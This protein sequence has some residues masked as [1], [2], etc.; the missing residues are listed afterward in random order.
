MAFLD[1]LIYGVRD[2][3][4]AGVAVTRR[5]QI[6]FVSGATVV[7][8]PATGRTDV[9]IATSGGAPP[10][11]T[12]IPYDNAGAWGTTIANGTSGQVLS[13]V[14]S[15]PAWAA[16][17]GGAPSG[18]AGGDLSSTYPNP[19]VAK[20]NGVVFPSGGATVG[21]SPH[22]SVAGTVAYN[23]LNLAGGAGWVSGLL[24]IANGG[25]GNAGGV[26]AMAA[27][28]IDWSLTP[29]Y[30]KTLTS[31]ANAITFSNQTAG[32][33]VVVRLTGAASTVTW[34]AGTKWAAG[35]APTQTASG[36]DVYTFFYD[37]TNVY[38]SAVQAFA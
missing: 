12:G 10:A 35:T 21:N 36:T 1:A 17:A 34:P 29:G 27:L 25:T 32:A 26:T 8:N 33:S 11:G 22:V 14:G 16:A 5:S 28:N 37:G 4:A 15:V 18:A 23:P 24:P 3:Y 38:G 19:T 20:V 13:I 9:T 6:N 2:V 7:D 31:G 30:A